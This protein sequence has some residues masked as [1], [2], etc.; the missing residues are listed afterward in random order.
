[1]AGG[2]KSRARTNVSKGK[3]GGP[4]GDLHRRTSKQRTA[5]GKKAPVTIS[6]VKAD[7][8]LG[9]RAKETI[10]KAIRHKKAEPPKPVL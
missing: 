6:Q 7:P 3:I 1:M 4:T 9:A 10:I 8:T 5:G 2:V